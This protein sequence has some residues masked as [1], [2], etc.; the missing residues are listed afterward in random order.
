VGGNHTDLPQLTGS[1][2]P[3]NWGEDH[4]LPRQWDAKGH[5][6]GKL[7]P[8]GW[9]LR[10]SPDGKSRELISSGYRNEYDIALNRH[11]EL[12]TFDADMEWDLGMPWYRPCRINH[13]VSGSEFGWRSGTGKWPEYYADSLPAV[14]DIG[15]ASPTG[16]VSGIGGKFPTRDQDAI[17]ALDWTYGTIWAVYPKPD[18]ASYTAE[19]KE[20][21]SG[22]PFAVTDAVIGADGA[23]AAVAKKAGASG[24]DANGGWYYDVDPAAGTPKKVHSC[25]A[26]CTAVKAGTKVETQIACP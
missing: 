24:C 14:V 3:T 15:P 17:F 18:G 12:F 10:V 25:P 1:R 22:T 20:F 5:A 6:R 26:T 8:G 2:M 19:V 9:V 4:L 23:G 21:A 16:V 13:A 7:A 11:G